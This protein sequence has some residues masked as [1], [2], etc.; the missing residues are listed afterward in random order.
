M[1]GKYK[2]IIQTMILIMGYMVN[3]TNLNAQG[4]NST[5]YD[6]KVSNSNINNSKH[7]S[8]HTKILTKNLEYPWGMAFLPNGDLLITEKKGRLRLF[9][10]GQL[11]SISGLP[12]TIEKIGQG[13]LLDIAIDPNFSQTKWIYLSYSGKG[14][15]GFST[16]VIRGKLA[17]SRLMNI[18][19]IFTQKP[20]LSGGYHFGSR[21][22]FMNDGTLLI[23][24]GD[25]GRMEMAQDPHNHIGTIAR[26]FPDGRIPNN[27][28]FI[29]NP[30]NGLASVFTYGNRNVQ[31]IAIR[32]KDGTVWAHEHGPK[33]GDEINI[34]EAGVNYGWPKI[35]YGINYN[36]RPISDK[37]TAPGMAQPV[38][39]WAP[40]I[41]PC[42]MTFYTG[43]HFPNWQGDIFVGALAKKHLRRIKLNGNKVIEQEILLPGI[44]RVRDV[45]SGP[46]GALY[47]LLDSQNGQ[48]IKILP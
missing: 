46:D 28:P 10:K 44:G 29:K 30:N 6:S 5:N 43:D 12:K 41:A 36:G 14:Q 32:P 2:W 26:I 31:G 39:Y 45:E 4:L 25:R 40:S 22:A 3:V 15:G 42:G 27:N 20:K 47:I 34:I 16:E 21:L 17:G 8:F 37:T 1:A 13:G 9:S 24:M 38:L 18:Q 33:G 35:T 48:L 11:T 23:T 7:H 19:T